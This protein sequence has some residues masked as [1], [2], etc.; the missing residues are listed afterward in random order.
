MCASDLIRYR[1][2]RSRFGL[3]MAVSIRFPPEITR[4]FLHA[5]IGSLYFWTKAPLLLWVRCM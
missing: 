5:V 1:L 2:S 4:T 3:P